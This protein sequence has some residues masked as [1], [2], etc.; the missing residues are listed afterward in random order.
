MKPTYEIIQI[1]GT[2]VNL[3]IDAAEKPTH[4]II[5]IIGSIGLKNSHITIKNANSKPT[6]ELIQIAGVYSKNITLDLT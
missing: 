2:G 4:E 1:A 5:Q 6:H 3:I